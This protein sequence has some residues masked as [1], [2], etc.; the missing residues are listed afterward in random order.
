MTWRDHVRLHLRQINLF[1]I[2]ELGTGSPSR[3]GERG[4]E[5]ARILFEQ[6]ISE[7]TYL[8]ML[9]GYEGPIGIGGSNM[10]SGGNI[11]NTLWGQ[12]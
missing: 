12:D 5:A 3:S 6:K 8:A 2:I 11:S 10:R 4:R 9:L 7:W 1:E